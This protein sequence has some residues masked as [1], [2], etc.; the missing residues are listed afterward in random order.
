MK[1]YKLK[2]VPTGLYYQPYK[3]KGSHLSKRGKIYQTQLNILSSSSYSN[4]G[5]EL[6]ILCEYGSQVYELTKNILNWSEAN[7]SYCGNKYGQVRCTTLVSD[8]VKEEI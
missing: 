4:G 5:N 2:H 1:P 7:R 6:V 8:W 3:H